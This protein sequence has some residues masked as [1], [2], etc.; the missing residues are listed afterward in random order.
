MGSTRYEGGTDHLRFDKIPLEKGKKL[1]KYKVINSTFC[2]VIG[3]IHWRGGW[4]Q[5]VFTADQNDSILKA[6]VFEL[7]L[8]KEQEKKL[9]NILIRYNVD[10]AKGC[11]KKI[12]EF[13]ERLMEDWRE[14][15]KKKCQKS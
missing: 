10:M 9:K 12:N 2:Q 14:S 6:S 5:Y 11:H 8:S 15:L 7:G 1:H 13:I 4:R 3:E